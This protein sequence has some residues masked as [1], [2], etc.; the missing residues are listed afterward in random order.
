MVREGSLE[1]DNL[2]AVLF[3]VDCPLDS[4][5]NRKEY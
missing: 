4:R 2:S 3:Q 1:L 5:E